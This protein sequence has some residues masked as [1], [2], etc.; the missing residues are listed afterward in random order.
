[1]RFSCVAQLTQV[2]LH[3]MMAAVCGPTILRFS[4]QDQT[5]RTGKAEALAEV[6]R[7]GAKQLAWLTYEESSA[8]RIN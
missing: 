8:F 1:M 7:Q 5:K 4:I 2:L 6:T 3:Y